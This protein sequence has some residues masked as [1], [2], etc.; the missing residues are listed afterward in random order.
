[1]CW[2]IIREK[3]KLCAFDYAEIIDS[4]RATFLYFGNWHQLCDHEPE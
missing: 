4:A 3:W 2:A 1:L